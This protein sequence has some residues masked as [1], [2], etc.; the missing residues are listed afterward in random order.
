[1]RAPQMDSRRYL[2]QMVDKAGREVGRWWQGHFD[3]E[4]L[5]DLCATAHRLAG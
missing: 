1:M 2:P 5:P 4:E 3:D